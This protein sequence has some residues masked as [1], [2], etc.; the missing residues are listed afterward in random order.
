MNQLVVLEHPVYIRQTH[1][2]STAYRTHSW[3]L[4]GVLIRQ[5]REGGAPDYSHGA[6][7]DRDLREIT[8]LYET[9]ARTRAMKARMRS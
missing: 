2:G 6:Y 4:N 7:Y 5:I 3:Y 1:G 9:A 8:E